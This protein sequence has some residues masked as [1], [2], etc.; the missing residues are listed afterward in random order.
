[1]NRKDV[2][3]VKSTDFDVL[4][5]QF[6]QKRCFQT[7][8]V[9]FDDQKVRIVQKVRFSNKVLN[10]LVNDI[11]QKGEIVRKIIENVLCPFLPND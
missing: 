11:F 5:A 2:Q 6:G 3:L 10:Q 8:V 4:R 1:M 7:E 9:C